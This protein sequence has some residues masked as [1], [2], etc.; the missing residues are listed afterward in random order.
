LLVWFNGSF[1]ELAGAASSALHRH[2]YGFGERHH[3]VWNAAI[4][5]FLPLILR[6]MLKRLAQL[7]QRKEYIAVQ[8]MEN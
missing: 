7:P 1:P 3:S 2:R 5:P 8:H 6:A 4:V